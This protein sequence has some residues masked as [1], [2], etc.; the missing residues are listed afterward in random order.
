MALPFFMHVSN[1][2]LQY[3]VLTETT[4]QVLTFKDKRET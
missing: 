3:P 4:D 1:D 2:N